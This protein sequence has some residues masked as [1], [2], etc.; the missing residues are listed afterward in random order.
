[1]LQYVTAETLT[2]TLTQVAGRRHGHTRNTLII[3]HYLI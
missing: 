1:M 3:K 2:E